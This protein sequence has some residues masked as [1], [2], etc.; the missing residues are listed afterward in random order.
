MSDDYKG[1]PIAA[2]RQPENRIVVSVY[3]LGYV[4]SARPVRADV[5]DFLGVLRAT[6]DAYLLDAADIVMPPLWML[7]E[8][9]RGL[10]TREH[11]ELVRLAALLRLNDFA[12]TLTSQR[13][14][15]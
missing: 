10:T 11:A 14:A 6:R 5:G 3:A 1:A 4:V 12:F 9:G 7:D 15:A 2:D 8:D 13:L